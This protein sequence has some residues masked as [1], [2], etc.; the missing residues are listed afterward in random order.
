MRPRS[1]QSENRVER[2]SL[3][4]QPLLE[5]L[6]GARVR[7][8]SSQLIPWEQDQVH[9]GARRSPA[10]FAN[11]AGNVQCR[12]A[13]VVATLHQRR[14]GLTIV[15]AFASRRGARMTPE[16]AEQR[17]GG[18]GRKCQHDRKESYSKH[19]TLETTSG[20]NKASRP[21]QSRRDLRGIGADSWL[22]NPME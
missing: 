16:L 15:A 12:D 9:R 14:R 5:N 19:D 3:E 4:R 18:R 7:R 11:E 22:P 8:R 21:R 6:R 20:K 17:R 13:T 10:R 1:L 2:S